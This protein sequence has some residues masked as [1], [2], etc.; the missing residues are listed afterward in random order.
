M[1]KM[2]E[3]PFFSFKTVILLKISMSRSKMQH[4]HAFF[5]KTEQQTSMKFPASGRP[6]TINLRFALVLVLSHLPLYVHKTERYKN[7]GSL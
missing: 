1:I 7:H 6:L 2:V 5:E 4:L 3:F